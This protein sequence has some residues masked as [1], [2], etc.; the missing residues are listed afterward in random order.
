ME[1]IGYSHADYT[2]V[3]GSK[4]VDMGVENALGNRGITCMK[5]PVSS[6]VD[7]FGSRALTG[8]GW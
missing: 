4:C 5:W 6:R 1:E 7:R 2:T 3:F 8:S